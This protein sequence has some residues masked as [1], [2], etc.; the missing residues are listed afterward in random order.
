MCS[1]R[2]A[3]KGPGITV[4]VNFT[5]TDLAWEATSGSFEPP[6]RMP[7]KHLRHHCFPRPVRRLA[8]PAARVDSNRCQAIVQYC[9]ISSNSSWPNSSILNVN[10]IKLSFKAQNETTFIA[11][12]RF[13]IPILIFLVV[14]HSELSAAR[15]DAVASQAEQPGRDRQGVRRG[16]SIGA[17]AAVPQIIAIMRAIAAAYRR[18]TRSAMLPADCSGAGSCEAPLLSALPARCAEGKFSTRQ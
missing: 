13:P 5:A 14:E 16:A 3:W 9:G 8:R 6:S 18:S 1:V 10:I 11:K 2:S 17:V 4:S 7:A 15:R 12:R